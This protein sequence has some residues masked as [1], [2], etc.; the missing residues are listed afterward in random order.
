[1]GAGSRWWYT[2]RW[3]LIMLCVIVW[4]FV[5]IQDTPWFQPKSEI[6]SEVTLPYQEKK[7]GTHSAS[8]SPSS[9]PAPA[10]QPSPTSAPTLSISPPNELTYPLNQLIIPDIPEVTQCEEPTEILPESKMRKVIDTV[11]GQPGIYVVWSESFR[12]K[13]FDYP[14]SVNIAQDYFCSNICSS[15]GNRGFRSCEPKEKHLR[16]MFLHIVLTPCSY[17]DKGAS[18][19]GGIYNRDM[20]MVAAHAGAKPAF[21]K[22]NIERYDKLAVALLPYSHTCQ[23]HFFS[24]TAPYLL[25][26]AEVLPDEVKLLV[27][28]NDCLKDLY[29]RFPSLDANRMVHF[30][31]Q[32]TYYAREMYS[33][34]PAPYGEHGI[35]GG[36]PQSDQSLQRIRNS[37]MPNLPPV[38]E[39]GKKL[40]LIDRSD[41]SARTCK[42]H[43]QLRETLQMKYKGGLE[44][45]NFVGTAMTQAENEALFQ[46]AAIVVGPHGG[47][48]M[49]LM[50]A[51]EGT[52]VVEIGYWGSSSMCFPSYYMTMAK[53]LGL[54]YWLI[55][56]N[57]EYNTKLDCPIDLITQT[58]DNILDSEK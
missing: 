6:E 40:V 39:R 20:Y 23:S 2:R 52:H 45:V 36:E 32:K 11:E 30:D 8:P 25:T 50:Y 56:A 16:E 13:V 29:E 9:S 15:G 31:E 14:K 34:V 10:Q 53:K 55:M 7:L 27:S 41:R 17:T 51:L 44:I 37:L 57:G 43:D 28:W 3:I 46:R 54:N 4:V 5:L 48:F 33:I 18:W 42:N 38:S 26:L 12:P 49:N 58:I 47:A 21:N 1:M 19:K 22:Q 24:G 35:L